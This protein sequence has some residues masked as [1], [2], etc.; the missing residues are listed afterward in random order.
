MT[1]DDEV[2][3]TG[4]NIVPESYGMDVP[5]SCTIVIIAGEK[6]QLYSKIKFSLD[7]SGHKF[8]HTIFNP[9]FCP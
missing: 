7:S 2:T 9:K 5:S 8:S 1:L 3:G 4:L 6:R